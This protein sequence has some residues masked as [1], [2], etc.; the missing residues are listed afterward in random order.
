MTNRKLTGF[1]AL[2][3]AAAAM[4]LSQSAFAQ[5]ATIKVFSQALGG[6]HP[7]QDQVPT[8]PVAQ[9]ISKKFGITMSI[10]TMNAVGDSNAKTALMIAS[11]DLMDLMCFQTPEL[12]KKA[13]TA[14]QLL[15]LDDLVAKYGQDILKNAP[16]MV[17]YA[18]NIAGTDIDGKTDGKL[19]IIIGQVGTLN[20]DA[21]RTIYN[22]YLRWD[23]YKKLGYPKLDTLSDYVDVLKKM[24]AL[25]P[26]NAA[27]QKNYGVGWGFADAP[28]QGDWVIWGMPTQYGWNCCDD[29]SM[30]CPTPDGDYPKFLTDV[31]SDFWKVIGFWNKAYRE[32]VLDPDS[33]TMKD[34][35]Y[36]ER[37]KA[38]RYFFSPNNQGLTSTNP[39]FAETGQT[40]KGFVQAP[41]LKDAKMYLVS[42]NL[43]YGN[44]SWAWGISKKTKYSD[45]IMQLINYL[46]T[47]D[48]MET[49]MNGIKG[50]DWDIVNGKPKVNQ[51]RIVGPQK[52]PDWEW[53]NGP[54]KYQI[55]QGLASM[56]IDPRYNTPIDFMSLPEVLTS[57]LTPFEKEYCAYYKVN[58]P[59]ELYLNK[60]SGIKNVIQDTPEQA[61][62][63]KLSGDM[64]DNSNKID[65]YGYQNFPKLIL[66]KTDAEFKA[67]QAEWIKGIQSLGYD[68]IVDWYYTERKAGLAILNK[69]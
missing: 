12:Y 26:T 1:L 57:K 8:D 44:S 14:K 62:M 28:W 24:M 40:G 45:K 36:Q 48:G 6:T 16:I 55:W 38:G 13:I 5:N 19:Y 39:A 53:N 35:N 47:F 23:L 42:W 27:G 51:A 59:I 60:Y 3:L 9:E 58:L 41:P 67:A 49:I 37:L 31:S 46:Y 29:W 25:E 21:A 66:P 33:F 34:A 56:T 4:F 50:K 54:A 15:P 22:N 69:K 18:R 61:Y 17:P 52:D 11:D 68:Q 64:L 63:K 2:A 10:T 30:F 20:Y 7:L 65:L 43:A 32:G